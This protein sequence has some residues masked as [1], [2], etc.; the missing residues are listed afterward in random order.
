ML[1]ALAFSPS[2]ACLSWPKGE[3]GLLVAP[4]LG[5]KHG[6]RGRSSL[7]VRAAQIPVRG[8]GRRPWQRLPTFEC[9]HGQHLRCLLAAGSEECV[10]AFAVPAG[11]KRAV[12]RLARGAAKA[13]S[14]NT[15]CINAIAFDGEH[16]GLV[17]NQ[18]RVS[19]N[20]REQLPLSSPGSL[21]GTLSSSAW[22]PGHRLL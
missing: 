20:L 16:R 5:S 14:L 11:T 6:P 17:Y 19:C 13:C 1:Y 18:E 9:S 2:G 15:A 4:Q 21:E 12:L 3:S 10:H 8:R 7:E 22:L